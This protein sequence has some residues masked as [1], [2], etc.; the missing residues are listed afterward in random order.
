MKT[1]SIASCIFGELSLH[2]LVADLNHVLDHIDVCRGIFFRYDDVFA[3]EA[4]LLSQTHL[5]EL[6]FDFLGP[7]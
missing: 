5:V 7:L 3:H 4:R 6:L 2:E 1:H